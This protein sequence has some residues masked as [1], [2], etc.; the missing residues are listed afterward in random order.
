M[1]PREALNNGV[2]ITLRA[3][4]PRKKGVNAQAL[5]SVPLSR[6]AGVCQSPR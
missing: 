5:C 3:M 6:K 2:T 4:V 1:L